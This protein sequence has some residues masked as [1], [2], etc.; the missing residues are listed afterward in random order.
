MTY[1]LDY[2]QKAA[3]LS[4]TVL[5][6]SVTELAR[7]R[8]FPALATFMEFAASKPL[9]LPV[10]ESG[11]FLNFMRKDLGNSGK[12]ANTMERFQIAHE[13]ANSLLLP[14]NRPTQVD[15]VRPFIT[16]EPAEKKHLAQLIDLVAGREDQDAWRKTLL[17]TIAGNINAPELL[18]ILKQ[19]NVD[20]DAYIGAV[21]NTSH[22]GQVCC[23]VQALLNFNLDLAKAWIAQTAPEH[24]N[25]HALST[26]PRRL[27][28]LSTALHTHPVL[29]LE[30]LQA[31]EDKLGLE[32]LAEF[33]IKLIDL[34]MKD[35]VTSNTPVDGDKLLQVI[36]TSDAQL[37][38]F[39]HA[40]QQP[41]DKGDG[42][43]GDA[44]CVQAL[45]SHCIELLPFFEAR[46]LATPENPG[47]VGL[48]H[49]LGSLSALVS[50]IASK[51][52]MAQTLAYMTDHGQSLG[53]VSDGDS[54]MR[55]LTREGREDD[56]LAKLHVLLT[57]GA[58]PGQKDS[59][60]RLARSYLAAPER[61][62]WDGVVHA[63]RARNASMELLDEMDAT[64][65]A[66]MP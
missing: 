59:R 5:L 66:P 32:S 16:L 43:K 24:F 64:S 17:S 63:Y 27:H 34:H 31:L 37:N 21:F 28:V 18:V 48:S 39:G 12:V 50:D 42:L 1:D 6:A 57:L 33:K 3:A 29:A 11:T 40:L 10:F 41:E 54:S 30:V 61:E 47:A 4:E 8:D 58:D 55:F 9:P 44:L 62:A 23:A 26:L 2:F 20:L 65:I 49:A 60:N 7:Q 45:R 53:N 15:V 56:R 51:R 19:K 46:V 14:L 13:Y 52:R 36:G 25:S 35:M 38:A 22:V